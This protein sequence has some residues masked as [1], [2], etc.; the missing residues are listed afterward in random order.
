VNER[1]DAIVVGAGI[2][3]ASIAYHLQRAGDQ[4]VLLIERGSAPGQGTTG[5][6]AAIIR[7]HY[8]NAVLSQLTGESIAILRDL[9]PHPGKLFTAAGWYF[10]VPGD[11]LEG[12]IQNVEMQK[13]AGVRTRLML[14]P[15][16]ERQTP[17]I[18][19]EGVAAV[20]H[21]PDSGYADPIECVEALVA[22]FQKLGGVVLV[23]TQCQSLT[24]NGNRI[25]GVVTTRGA[26]TTDCTVNACGPWSMALAATGQ[27][28][29]PLSIFR[30]QETVWQCRGR[31][32]MPVCSI[33]DAVDAIYL[34]PMQ[35]GR[36][37]IGRGFPKEYEKANPDAFDKRASDDF[38]N[39]VLDRIGRR[40]PA[41]AGV[42]YLHGFASLYDVTPDWYP[43]AGPRRDVSGYVDACG[44]SG[45]GFKLAPAIGRHLACWIRG[46]A[47][48]E[49]FQRLSYNRVI[50][51]R[52]FAQKFGGNRG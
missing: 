1:F 13:A 42:R 41:L 51:G 4:R 34:R 24:R 6:S 40:F 38:V 47:V 32:E 19:P 25:T 50:D 39:D 27:I 14:P 30:E 48:S 3:G 2:F 29:L 7:Q 11:N 44:G 16:F 10:L 17:W 15:E 8:S 46:E 18:N 9:E 52:L 26:F 35:Q 23:G 43:F 21:E 49:E 31:A 36:Y 28:Q 20:V 5:A 22:A 12:A 37:T 33:S 45:H